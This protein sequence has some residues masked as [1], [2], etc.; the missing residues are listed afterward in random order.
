MRLIDT[1]CHVQFDAYDS[2]RDAL[3]VSCNEKEIGLMVVGCDEKSS[4]DA[5]ALAEK[6]GSTPVFCIFCSVGQHPTDSAEPFD[7][8]K[9]LELAKSSKKVRAIGEC[10][11]DYY[12]LSKDEKERVVE[13]EQQKELFF[14]HI[15]LSSELNLPLIIHCRDAHEDMIEMLTHSYGTETGTETAPD[16]VF[17]EHGVM[18]CF[19]GTV[20]DAQ[21]YLDMGFMISFTGIIT[22]TNQYDDV[23]RHVPL[24]KILIETDAPFLSPVPYRGKRNSPEYVEYIARRIAEIKGVPFEHVAETATINAIRLF[25]ISS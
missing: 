4:R 15:N 25:K 11:L 6:T 19:T 1:H 14:Q 22:F 8:K 5:I 20:R 17:R 7:Y 12:H 10:G 24:E 9:F 18:H 23:V 3:I 13:I 21:S 16:S 2:D